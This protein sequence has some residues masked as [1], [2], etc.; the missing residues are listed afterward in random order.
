MPS[1]SGKNKEK[2]TN[3]QSSNKS[4]LNTQLL[5]KLMNNS[6]KLFLEFQTMNKF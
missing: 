5:E 3:N 6:A 4:L 1:F 2:I